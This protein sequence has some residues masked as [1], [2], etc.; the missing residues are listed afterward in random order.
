M[1][2]VAHTL[3]GEGF[4]ASEDGSGRGTPLVPDVA[5][6]LQ[7]RDAKGAD[8][9]TKEGHLIPVP[10]LEAGARTGKSTDDPRAGM[11]IGEP[12]DPMFTLQ[13]S[14]QHAVAFDCKGSQVQTETDGT[15]PPLRA[16]NA[17]GSHQNGGGQLAVAF[18]SRFVRNG[19]GA[20]SDVVPPLKAESGNTGKGDSA[21]LVAFTQNSRSEVR[22]M[23][24][25]GAISAQPGVQQQTYVNAAMAVR[26]LTPRECERLQGFSDDYTL[27]PYRGK[28]M[29]DGPRYR[30][31]GNSMAVPVMR[32]IGERIDMVERLCR[33]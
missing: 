6:A 32:K 2:A 24:Y 8:S 26:R 31:L 28:L 1:Q 33:T 3:R 22:A 18:E 16:M 14:K 11:G 29:A 10:I 21:P 4:D 13:S 17:D 12:G 25:A 30:M 9:N 5:W 19:R 7:E 15:A 20:P 23:P 27:V